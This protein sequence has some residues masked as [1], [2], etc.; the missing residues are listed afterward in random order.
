MEKPFYRRDGYSLEENIEVLKELIKKAG[1]IGAK[2]I[3]LPVLENAEIRCQEEEDILTEAVYKVLPTLE[4]QGIRIGFETELPIEKYLGLV[5][6]FHSEYVGA[7]YDAGNCAAC[8]HDMLQDMKVLGRHVISV[9]VKD[10]L[11]AGKSVFLGTGDTNFKE[12]I[13]YLIKNGYTGNFVLQTYFE[14][15]YIG[16]AAE[17]LQYI[18]GIIKG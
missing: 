7:Y 13:P 8:G 17:G 14:D 5:S 18:R 1:E 4:E 15:D 12:G 10:R 3:L 9:H 2:T 11:N 6:K 16:A